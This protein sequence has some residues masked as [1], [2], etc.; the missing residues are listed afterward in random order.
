MDLRSSMGRLMVCIGL[1]FAMNV[2]ADGHGEVFELRT[3]TANEGK[4]D[5]LEARFR[6]HTMTLFEKHGMR[7][8]GYWTPV[9]QPDTLIYIIAHASRETAGTNWRAFGTDPEW[10][11]VFQ[12]SRKDGPLIKD[13]VSVYM[14]A[15]DYSPTL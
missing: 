10:Q 15:T 7:N 6:D 13:I 4:L 2:M 8:V 1:L 3:Y 12:D 9:D 11:R 5:A 14:S